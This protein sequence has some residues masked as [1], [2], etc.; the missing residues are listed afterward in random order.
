MEI[1]LILLLLVVTGYLLFRIAHEYDIDLN[2]LYLLF[3]E[4]ALATLYYN[5]LEVGDFLRYFSEG[6]DLSEIGSIEYVKPGTYF[7]IFISHILHSIGP[8]SRLGMFALFSLCGFMGHLFLIAT[9][10]PFLK[11]PRD[12]YWF[13]LFF[14]PG[15]HIWTCALGKDSLIFL[16]LCYILFAISQGRWPLVQLC[17]SFILV[18]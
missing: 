9:C 3:A 10:R 11:L 13:I 7:V 12:Q 8:F 16:P 18:F 6:Y 14:L 17:L 15:L 4:H 5:S 2:L 1:P